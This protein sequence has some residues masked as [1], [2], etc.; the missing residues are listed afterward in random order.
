MPG[1]MPSAFMRAAS[2]YQTTTLFLGPGKRNSYRHLE[3][4]YPRI[5][6]KPLHVPANPRSLGNETA[7]ND[8]VILTQKPNYQTDPRWLDEGQRPD[9]LKENG[10][11]MLRPYQKRAVQSI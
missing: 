10:L 5:I 4:P 3:I 6:K 2:F 8:Y 7:D 9:F 1:T 11:M